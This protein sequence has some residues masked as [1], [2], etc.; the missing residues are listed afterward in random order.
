MNDTPTPETDGKAYVSVKMTADGPRD[1]PLV[2]PADFARKLERERDELAAC[3]ASEK[4]TRNHIVELAAKTERELAELKQSI[5]NLSHPNCHMLLRERDEA[6]EAIDALERQNARIPRS[7]MDL[8]ELLARHGVIQSCAIED[9]ED[10]DG[11]ATLDRI[12][13]AHAELISSESSSCS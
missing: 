10:Y 6:R 13:A 2:V 12:Y 5:T 3:L 4:I 7:G 1:G 9:W 8:A 11:G